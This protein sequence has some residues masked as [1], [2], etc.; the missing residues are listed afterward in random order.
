VLVINSM[1][2]IKNVFTYKSNVDE[3]VSGQYDVRVWYRNLIRKSSGAS[4][5]LYEVWRIRESLHVLYMMLEIKNVF[6][7]LLNV[8]GVV[9]GQCSTRGRNVSVKILTNE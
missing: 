3:C 6:T 2:E 5:G 8:I 4:Y 7:D 9:S 1:L